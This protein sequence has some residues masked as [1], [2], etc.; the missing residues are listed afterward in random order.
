MQDN[1]RPK[2]ASGQEIPDYETYDFS[3]VWRGRGLQNRVER[4]IVSRWA[5]GDTGIELGGGYGRIAQALEGKIGTM[6]MLD[7]SLNNLK[8][9]SSTLKKTT[10][11]RATFERLPFDDNVFDFVAVVRVIH[12]LAGPSRLLDEIVRISRN[13]GTFVLGIANETTLA[14]RRNRKLWVTPEGHRVYPTPLSKFEHPG[15]AR[16]E[17]RGVGVFD[18]PLGRQVERIF[19]LSSLDLG[20]AR[21]WPAK[22]MLFVRYT[23]RK[24]A[25]RSE[26][27][28]NC[29]SCGGHIVGRR[30]QNCGRSYGQI[31]DLV[32]Q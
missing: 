26:P 21:L 24:P 15:L 18:N 25:A 13:G 28:V 10:L 5:K 20:T 6:F 32:G 12:H 9:A 14:W 27:F 1:A 19:P 4:L 7:Y 29:S 17:I 2:P 16:V 22:S 11:V 30:C 3:S 8:R 31:I 23:V